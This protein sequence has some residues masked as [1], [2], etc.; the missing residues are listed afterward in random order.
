MQTRYKAFKLSSAIAL[1]LL[2]TSVFAAERYQV[3]T[4]H[5]YILF[6]VKHF[7]IGYSYGRFDGPT[8]SIVWEQANPANS[9]IEMTVNA[10]DVNTADGKRDQHLRSADFLN[11]EKYTAIAFKSTSVRQLS[12]DAYEVTG[13]LTLL[14]KTRPIAMTVR[15]TGVGKDPWGDYRRGFETNFVIKRSDW[16]MDFMLDGV[17]DEVELTVS[18]EG[19]RQ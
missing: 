5:T 17:S 1:L 4:A 6:K 9:S 13:E 11:V 12:A 10:V 7:D 14:G 15:Q 8:G 3:D 19:I 2:A 18:I 16:G